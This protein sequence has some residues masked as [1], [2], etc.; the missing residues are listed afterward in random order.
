MLRKLFDKKYL[1]CFENQRFFNNFNLITIIF[2]NV[3]EIKKKCVHVNAIWKKNA[4]G[5]RDKI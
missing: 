4:V 1:N 2:E 5:S 3:L